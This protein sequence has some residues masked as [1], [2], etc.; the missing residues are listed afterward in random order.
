MI[1]TY[2]PNSLLTKQSAKTI[3]GE[4]YGWETHILYLAPHKQNNLGK[5]LCPKASDGCAKACLFSAGRGKF[6]NVIKG[7]INKTH[8]FLTEKD[9]FLEKLYKELLNIDIKDASVQDIIPLYDTKRQCVRLN[10][11]SDLPWESIKYKG[12]S[13]L[14]H[15]PNL[16]FFDYTKDKNRV[17]KN[18]LRNYH[19]T[20]SRSETNHNDCEEVLKSGFNVAVVYNRTFYMDNIKDSS[21]VSNIMFNHPYKIIDGDQ[22][23]LRFLDDKNVIVG[24]SAKGDGKKDKSGF[25]I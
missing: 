16:Q 23:D 25:V 5:N 15:F 1:E 21:A 2:K 19:L 10:G 6:S 18:T 17:L 22:S 12:K 24:L 9:W 14:E 8:L 4:K 3:K 7:R 11:T 13:L 20:F